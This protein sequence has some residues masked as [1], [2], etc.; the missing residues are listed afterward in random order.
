MQVSGDYSGAMPP[1]PTPAS[2]GPEKSPQGHVDSVL[3]VV[4]PEVMPGAGRP[5]SAGITRTPAPEGLGAAGV[6]VPH[7]VRVGNR[8][9]VSLLLK[10]LKK[11]Q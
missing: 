2:C 4:A 7:P 8:G 9:L 6:H 3:Q 5:T 10:Q 11:C 1:P